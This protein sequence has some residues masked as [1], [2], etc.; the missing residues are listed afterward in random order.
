MKRLKYGILGVLIAEIIYLFTKDEN[1]KQEID[2]TKWRKKA[3]VLWRELVDL[4]KD[5][6]NKVSSGEYKDK[7]VEAKDHLSTKFQELENYSHTL[8]DKKLKDILG[9]IQASM[10]TM[11]SGLIGEKDT[12]AQK[13]SNKPNKKTSHKA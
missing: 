5:L 6:R 9:D 12:H 4:N 13:P 8:G 10:H 11:R 1:L 3:Q 7:L 2:K